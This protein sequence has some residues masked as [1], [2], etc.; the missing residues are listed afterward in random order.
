MVGWDNLRNDGENIFDTYEKNID[1]TARNPGKNE[2]NSNSY[3]EL[4]LKGGKYLDK[5]MEW[6]D[7][8]PAPGKAERIV[9][10]EYFK[11]NPPLIPNEE[12]YDY[13]NPET[14]INT[15]PLDP[16]W[17][18]G[19]AFD[20]TEDQRG[21]IVNNTTEE[22]H[23]RAHF[24]TT[25]ATRNPLRLFQF[26]H[27]YRGQKKV[28]PFRKRKIGARSDRKLIKIPSFDEIPCECGKPDFV[29]NKENQIK[30]C[31]NCPEYQQS[32][33]LDMNIPSPKSSVGYETHSESRNP[34]NIG[35]WVTNLYE[36]NQKNFMNHEQIKINDLLKIIQY[37]HPPLSDEGTELVTTDADGNETRNKE[38]IKILFES[39]GKRGEL[40]EFLQLYTNFIWSHG[41][42]D[43]Q[44]KRLMS[45]FV[46]KDHFNK[47][48]SS[49]G[50]STLPARFYRQKDSAGNPVS[51]KNIKY[52]NR[53]TLKPEE[54][55]RKT[56]EVPHPSDN[57]CQM[58]EIFHAEHLSKSLFVAVYFLNQRKPISNHELYEAHHRL[59]QLDDWKPMHIID[60]VNAMIRIAIYH[61]KK[62]DFEDDHCALCKCRKEENCCL[63][64]DD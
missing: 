39:Q 61:D 51:S 26:F 27:K 7:L 63:Q 41:M 57:D 31:K 21:E 35:W 20:F 29:T 55:K 43:A 36:R 62:I 44:R 4:L 30:Y 37:L 10:A 23:F 64:L 14:P 34:L 50:S 56:P 59:L 58:A 11:F 48:K 1:M 13:R 18:K 28:R 17:K 42:T 49:M 24:F 12:I 9:P 52:M 22:S 6:H 45:S 32:P 33:E 60:T 15:S 8:N 38:S 46:W 5:I 25:R 53:T 3:D 47:T 16:K 40:H 54:I 2:E 19:I